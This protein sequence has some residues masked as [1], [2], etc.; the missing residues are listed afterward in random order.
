[1]IKKYTQFI[2]KRFAQHKHTLKDPEIMHP[3]R[4]WLI[5]LAFMLTLFLSTTFWSVGVYI[6]NRDLSLSQIPVGTE[7]AAVYRESVVKE[8]IAI[9]SARE[10]ALSRLLNGVAAPAP[11]ES[12]EVT[13]TTTEGALEELG[14]TAS[15]T[16]GE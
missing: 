15:S 9:F 13:A 3:E 16:E 1:M 12:D 2:T 4:E 14:D 8:G 6:A 5:G 7:Q 10:E 11:I